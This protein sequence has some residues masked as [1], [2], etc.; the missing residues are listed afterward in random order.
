MNSRNFES[1]TLTGQ[2]SPLAMISKSFLLYELITS[3]C[4]LLFPY[5][6]PFS[7]IGNYKETLLY[8]R[9]VIIFTLIKRGNYS[10]AIK[11]ITINNFQ[12]IIK[13]TVSLKT[14]FRTSISKWNDS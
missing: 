3:T 14:M 5:N 9:E 7:K 6:L 8:S 1:S 4:R 12:N 11:N 13:T 2:Y 10:I